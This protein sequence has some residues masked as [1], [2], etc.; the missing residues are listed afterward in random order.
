M[1]A[2]SRRFAYVPDADTALVDR[3][4]AVFEALPASESEGSVDVLR[5]RLDPRACLGADWSSVGA[6][7]GTRP[8]AVKSVLLTFTSEVGAD[9]KERVVDDL[10]MG[11]REWQGED[12]RTL[13]D[14]K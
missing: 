14:L 9:V 5:L 8:C 4:E 11:L 7:L 12:T 3:L 6:D 10:R 13:V 1:S 2:K